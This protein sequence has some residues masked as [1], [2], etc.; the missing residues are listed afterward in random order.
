MNFILR[1]IDSGGLESNES[2][3]DHYSVINA[4]A[5]K[6]HFEESAKSSFKGF[7]DVDQQVRDIKEISHAIIVFN[8]GSEI[9]FLFKKHQNYIMTESGKT[10]DN[11][12]FTR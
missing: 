6:E 7:K 1:V 4:F 10:F 12:S 8:N 2:I 5:Q 3:G 9:R 11:L